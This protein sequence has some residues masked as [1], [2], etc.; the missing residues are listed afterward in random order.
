[1]KTQVPLNSVQFIDF[2]EVSQQDEI[3][4]DKFISKR[5]AKINSK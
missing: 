1:M 3:L 2:K 5:Q 4:S